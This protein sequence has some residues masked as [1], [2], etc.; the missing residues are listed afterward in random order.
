MKKILKNYKKINIILIGMKI[1]NN[2]RCQKKKEV[3]LNKLKL[4]NKGER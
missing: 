2:K 3:S 1:K 4:F